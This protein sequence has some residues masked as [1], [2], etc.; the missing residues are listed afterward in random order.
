MYSITPG[1]RRL[2][3]LLADEYASYDG[4]GTVVS[5]IRTTCGELVPTTGEKQLYYVVWPCHVRASHIICV[6]R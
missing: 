5:S 3:A 1:S 4:I 6:G 2:G